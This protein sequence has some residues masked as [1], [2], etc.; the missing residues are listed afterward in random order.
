MARP[1]RQVGAAGA[2][3][4]I[5]CPGQLLEARLL[6][7]GPDPLAGLAGGGGGFH[8]WQRVVQAQ[9]AADALLEGRRHRPG[10]M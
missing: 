8:N 1:G 9:H 2:V 10:F 5:D 6:A 4:L 3:F 7:L